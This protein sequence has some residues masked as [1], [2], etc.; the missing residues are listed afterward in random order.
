[1]V[2]RENRRSRNSADE[3]TSRSPATAGRIEPPVNTSRQQRAPS[4]AASATDRAAAGR[5][6]A[7]PARLGAPATPIAAA[8]PAAP[9][10]SSTARRGDAAAPAC[11][12]KQPQSTRPD[13]HASACV[14]ANAANTAAR[15]KPEI[16]AG[17]NSASE[18]TASS[19]TD[20]PRIAA[21]ARGAP[22]RASAPEP[23]PGCRNLAAPASPSTTASVV[24]TLAPNALSI[25]YISPDVTTIQL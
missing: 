6:D 8:R 11:S 25:L 23:I 24:T 15:T 2:R 13:R 22:I 18:A 4:D 17:A 12:P 20:S 3:A 16:R 1:M 21:N 9:L 19:A 10:V 5:L 7:R 14:M